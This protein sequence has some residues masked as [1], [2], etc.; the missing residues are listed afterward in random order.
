MQA[1]V[2]FK[3]RETR[4]RDTL[5]AGVKRQVMEPMTGRGTSRRLDTTRPSSSTTRPD[6]PRVHARCYYYASLDAGPRLDFVSVPGSPAGARCNVGKPCVRSLG[7][8]Y[9]RK[10]KHDY[11]SELCAGSK[12]TFFYGRSRRTGSMLELFFFLHV[13]SR[14]K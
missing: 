1:N 8:Y 7:T 14:R 9:L 11:S 2:A 13:G 10:K 3:I 4:A 6:I 12:N 5:G